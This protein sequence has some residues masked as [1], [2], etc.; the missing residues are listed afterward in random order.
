[1]ADCECVERFSSCNGKTTQQEPGIVESMASGTLAVRRFA[2]GLLFLLSVLL[3]VLPVSACAEE[4][5]LRLLIWEGY[6]P[7]E[8]VRKFEKETEEKY[9]KK[10]KL[11]ILLAE[12]TDDFY[13][14]IRNKR[15]DVATLS[16]YTMKDERFN[17]IAKGLLLPF[18][19]ENIP[20]HA[21]VVPDIKMADYHVTDGKV[22][23]VPVANGPYG[24]AYNT[25]MIEHAPKSWKILWDPAYKDKYAIGAQEYLYNVNITAMAM[26]YQRESISSYAALN[27]NEVK[28]KLR[29]L[30]VNAH[31]LWVGV[32]QPE[33]LLG[34]SFATSWGD[35][36][37]SLRR[38]GEIWKMAEPVEGTMW[39]IDEY[40]LTWALAEK[41]FLKKVA[42]EWI[43]RSLSPVFQ[44]EHIVR[45]VGNFPV[46]TNISDMLTDEEKEKVQIASKPGDFA[47]KPILQRTYSKRDRNGLK[48]LWTEA[49]EGISVCVVSVGI[50]VNCR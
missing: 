42:E 6:A 13:D 2:Q 15:V 29:Q 21:H 9:G 34:M 27:N 30:A 1:M 11:D 10:V 23:G 39:W 17:F 7:E 31:A 22:Y 33:D 46:V 50:G 32:D 37:S 44:V 47:G 25:G 3:L 8:Y 41:P 45:E 12:S 48:L 18:D 19:L 36:F 24:L 40:A 16:H 26:G 28:E 20:N 49:M 38:Q 35:S 4:N 5:V 14:T 43:N